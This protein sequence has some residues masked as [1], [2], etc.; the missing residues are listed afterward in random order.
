MQLLA[1]ASTSFANAQALS[2]RRFLEVFH[3]V[4]VA[5]ICGKLLVG[6]KREKLDLFRL[7][8]YL[9]LNSFPD[10]AL[11]VKKIILPT[12]IACPDDHS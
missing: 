12:V 4:S 6:I 10:T 1:I 11:K 7:L 2:K 3:F 9:G 5:C 8:C